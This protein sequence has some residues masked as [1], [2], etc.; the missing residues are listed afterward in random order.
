MTYLTVAIQVT[1]RDSTIA[2][3]GT[4]QEA[5]AEM[6]ELRLDYLETLQPAVVQE[7]VE[8]S[9]QSQLPLIATCRPRWEGGHFKGSEEERQNLLRTALTA[10]AEYVDIELACLDQDECRVLELL[11]QAGDRVILSSHDF[12]GVPANM[13]D[14]MEKMQQQG[15]AVNKI[16]YQ[17][18]EITDCLGV[19]DLLQTSRGKATMIGLAMGQTGVMTR[20]LA[21]KM[22]AFLTF[23]SVA[24][25]EGTAP[26]Q[27]TVAEMKQ[28]YRWDAL[29]AD[30][31]V[32]G[33]IG[34]PIGH[35]KSPA[36]HN[37]AF[38]ETGFNGVYLPF[39][40]ETPWNKFRDFVDALRERT[41]LDVRGLSVTIPHKHNALQY[42]E[43]TGGNLEPLAAKIG[44]VNTLVLDKDGLVS[45]Y[46]T[47]YAGA[48]NA[49]THTLGIERKD[50]K[51]MPAAII[52]AGGVARAL[53]AG[54]TDVGCNVTLYNRTVEKAQGL[55]EEFECDYA[56]LDALGKMEAKLVVNATR[57]GMYPEVEASPL[58]EKCLR[59]DM[60][61]FDTVYNPAKTLLLQQAEN[62]GAKT[63]DGMSMFVNQAAT[64]FEL[65]TGKNAPRGVMRAVLE[66]HLL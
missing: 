36:V 54:L 14:L 28:V 65:F 57:I 7:I 61:V 3:C 35:S 49:I 51:G 44:S 40:V 59:R 31:V 15:S 56:G 63:I 6:I 41:W 66:A 5:G 55:A 39:L 19:L 1:D 10:G 22:G 50:L 21:K 9:K 13:T 32:C 33:V 37:A 24:E 42:V 18:E 27:I 64:Q 29:D 12:E 45:G 47:D 52:G 48:L 30:T 58:P 20:V 16:A 43:E 38:T 34:N 53:A 11:D 60:A 2:A 26:G 8:I 46:N 4:A 25:G 17:A 23:A 62:I